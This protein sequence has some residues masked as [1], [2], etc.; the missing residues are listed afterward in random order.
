[1]GTSQPVE[2]SEVAEVTNLAAGVVARVEPDAV[3]LPAAPSMWREF[4]RLERL[5]TSAKTLLARRVDESKQWKREGFRSAAEQL[6]SLGGTTIGAARD[7]LAVS[8]AVRSLPSTEAAVRAGSLSSAQASAVA[9]AAASDPASEARLLEQA[10]T[11]S[12]AELREECLRTKANADPDRDTTYRRIHEQRRLRT[13]TDAEGAWNLVARGTPDAGA[14]VIAALEPLIDE[15]F[16]KAREG[17]EREPREAYAFDAL[18][19]LA[20]QP[21]GAAGPDRA[22]TKRQNPRF[23]SL[24]RVDLTA[25]TRGRTAADETCE[26]SGLGP[27]PVSRARELLG[28]STL[29]LVITK[30]VDVANVTHLG[31]GPSAAQRIALLWSSPTCTVEGCT[32]TRVEIDH[33]VPWADDPRTRLDNLD[34]LCSHHHDRKTSDG[35]ALVPGT[36]KRPMVPRGDPRHPHRRGAGR[37]PPDENAA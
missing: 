11:S 29:R 26:L 7:A 21:I 2:L 18:V 9:S 27:I 8:S 15:R 34:P 25:L 37:A 20:A 32:R 10:E 31:R 3:P 14:A 1:V 28:V 6:A 24:L 17:G 36:G 33:R 5:A 12:L 13:W 23:L 22:S 30:G 35:W 16:T 4:D 19:G